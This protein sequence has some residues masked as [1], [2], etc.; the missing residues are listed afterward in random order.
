[1]AYSKKRNAEEHSAGFEKYK[2]YY[3]NGWYTAVM[4]SNLVVK[5]KLTPEE[6]NEIV[7]AEAFK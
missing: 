4:L 5:G 2:K 6:Y 3:D 7:G 1:M